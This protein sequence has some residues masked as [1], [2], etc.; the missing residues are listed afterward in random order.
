MITKNRQRSNRQRFQDRIV[1]FNDK[2][3]ERGYTK[4]GRIKGRVAF[5]YMYS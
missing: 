5:I 3:F 1:F 2:N 4:E